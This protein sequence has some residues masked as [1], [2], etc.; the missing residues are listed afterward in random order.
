MMIGSS[1]LVL[2]VPERRMKGGFLNEFGGTCCEFD[3]LVMVFNL[4]VMN[5]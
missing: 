3:G 5:S 1:V 4:L 2:H